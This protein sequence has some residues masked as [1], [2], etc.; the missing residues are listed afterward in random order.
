VTVRVTLACD[1]WLKYTASKAAAMARAGADV[2]LLCR[3]HAQEFHGDTA[4]REATLAEPREAGVTVLQ[5]PGRIW[6]PHAIPALAR[7]RREIHR[8]APQVVHLHDVS[9]DP[10]VIALL[11]RVP[12]VMTVHDPTPHP[13]HPEVRLRARRWML[14]ASRRT[15]RA[16][17]S[18]I[19]IH[20]ED[21]RP[22]IDLRPSQRCVVIPHGLYILSEPLP[23]PAAPALGFFGRLEPY[24]GLDVL[25]AAMPRIWEVRPEVELRVAGTGSMTLPLEDPRVR[26]DNTYVPESELE[27]FFRGTSLAVLPYI[28][29]S[30]TGA[31]STAVGFGVPV[32][33]SRVG[34]LP[35]LVL[36][37]SY[38][39]EAGDH[40]ALAGAILSHLDD[41][42][43]VRRRV[44]A[45]VA[46]PNSWDAVGERLL[47]IYA[48]VA[49][50]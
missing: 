3:E 50:A 30:Q 2:Q 19:V 40:T 34:G 1:W 6:D 24:K 36:D 17:A 45:E 9:V 20:S 16:R 12:T 4:E 25:A 28:E 33:A 38:L 48:E 5:A 15:L 39:F 35:D 27:S 13:G 44:L 49:G 31:G 7:I 11:P 29:A 14:D 46:R 41:G 37:D 10:R 21:L 47:G 32:V 22:L 26:F 18:V 42:P 23:P 43:A 8:F